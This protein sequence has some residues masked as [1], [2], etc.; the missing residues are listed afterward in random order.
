M[1]NKNKKNKYSLQN[2]TEINEITTSHFLRLVSQDAGFTLSDTKI[3]WR[4]IMRI[5]GRA[6]VSEKTL[7]LR[8]L[9]KIY[10][11]T[12]PPRK[13]W[14]GLKNKEGWVDESK[15]IVFQFSKS[16]KELLYDYVYSGG[17]NSAKYFND[18]E[19]DNFEDEDEF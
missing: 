14:L 10:V 3:F 1:L 6:I 8:G 2:R 15:R 5:M 11:K 7:K 18:I 13:M 9:G 4:S 19:S 12:I 16:L 17:R